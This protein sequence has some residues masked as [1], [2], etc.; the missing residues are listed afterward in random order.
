M[1]MIETSSL[2]WRLLH[3]RQSFIVFCW[4]W[5]PGFNQVQAFGNAG[6]Y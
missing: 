3:M 5:V 1:A 2:D 6:T 4:Q